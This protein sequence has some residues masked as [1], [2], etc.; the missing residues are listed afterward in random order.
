MH[1]SPVALEKARFGEGG[2]HSL[3]VARS[4]QKM[5]DLGEGIRQDRRCKVIV[6]V[7]ATAPLCGG[8]GV[9]GVVFWRAPPSVKSGEYRGAKTLDAQAENPLTDL[10]KRTA[11][12]TPAKGIFHP[13]F[14]GK[15]GPENFGSL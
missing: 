5:L 2:R 10:Q 9:F 15:K 3:P 13:N 6:P 11:M 1:S 12:L 7:Q 14:S 4:E 8:F